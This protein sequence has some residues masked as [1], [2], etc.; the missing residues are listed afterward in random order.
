[1]SDLKLTMTLAYGPRNVFDNQT[2]GSLAD[3]QIAY[4][5][6]RDLSGLGASQWGTG[7]VHQGKKPFAMISYNGRAWTKDGKTLIA[8]IPNQEPAQ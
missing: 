7:K 6:A 3:A 1:M 4:A 2:F 5:D 8:E